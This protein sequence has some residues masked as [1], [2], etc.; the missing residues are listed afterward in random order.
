MPEE[1]S[2]HQKL[3]EQTVKKM[4]TTPKEQAAQKS[5]SA[6]SQPRK[7]KAD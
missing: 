6:K 4:A 5:N 2:D 7:P 1:K 3:F